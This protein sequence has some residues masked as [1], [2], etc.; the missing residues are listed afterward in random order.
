MEK[1]LRKTFLLC[2]RVDEGCP[3]SAKAHKVVEQPCEGC[4][5]TVYVTPRNLVLK[6]ARNAS[7]MCRL[8]V[9]KDCVNPVFSWARD[10]LKKV[11]EESEGN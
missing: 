9:A 3:E 11:R 8:C 2:Q 4:G 6:A 7:V 10:E 5:A 1:M